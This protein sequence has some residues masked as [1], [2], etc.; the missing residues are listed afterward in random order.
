MNLVRA[1]VP[2]VT[3]PPPVRG[4]EAERILAGEL[5]A[6]LR[7]LAQS[8]TEWAEML[9]GQ[10]VNHV[11]EVWSGTFDATALITRNYHVAAGAIEVTN[12]SVAGIITVS[13]AAPS[14]PAVPTGT[15]TYLVPAG[16]SRTI[17]L[18]SRQLTL[19]GTNTDRVAFQVFTSAPRP[20][21]GR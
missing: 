16:A 2:D 8:S 18:A 3:A 12:L 21:A 14:G 20:V 4:R 17:A 9:A 13:S 6:E 10:I 19:F 15:G 11:L 1:R 5:L 7:H